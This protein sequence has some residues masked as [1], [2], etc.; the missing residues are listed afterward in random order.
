[1]LPRL[2]ASLRR[3]AALAGLI[4]GLSALNASAGALDAPAAPDNAGS[5]LY[6]IT[7]VYN[8]INNGEAGT[9]RSTFAEPTAAP[10]PTGHTL[11]ELYN[12]AS[13]RARPA[14]TGQ[15][16]CYDAAGTVISCSGTGQDGALQ[17]GVP[18]PSPRFTDNGNG[19]VTDN[20]SG[21]IWLKDAN[22]FGTR[23]WADALAAANTLNS[24]ECSL[25]DSSA[26]GA[27]RLPNIKEL[28]SLVDFSRVNPVLPSGYPFSGVQSDNYWS[29]T[30]YA[31]NTSNA[32]NLNLNNG[33]VN[34][35]D[36]TNTNYVWPVR[37]GQ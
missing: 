37:G 14:Q 31:D 35:D 4:L 34:N 25:S 7:D 15:T 13:Q 30:S 23:T 21:L 16:I 18:S 8:R 9:L 20:L 3:P 29:S 28:Q 5:A 36:K 19:T 10:A 11:T 6:T 32:W 27:W 17:K 12:L 33:N 26:E 2:A 1:M 22:C 24:G